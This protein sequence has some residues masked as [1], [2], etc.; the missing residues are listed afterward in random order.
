MSTFSYPATRAPSGGHAWERSN[1]AV[2]FSTGLSRVTHFPSRKSI[3]GRSMLSES[4]STW[5]LV[6]ALSGPL[7]WYSRDAI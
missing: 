1:N 6:L 5:F 2:S 4:A 7:I 3:R